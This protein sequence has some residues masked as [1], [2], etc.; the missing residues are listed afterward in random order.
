MQGGAV[1]ICHNADGSDAAV[2][3][4]I[5]INQNLRA[6]LI[7]FFFFNFLSVTNINALFPANHQYTNHY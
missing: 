6:N 4:W 7:C 1:Q 2:T 5:L 3:M